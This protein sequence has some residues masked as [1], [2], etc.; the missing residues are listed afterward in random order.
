MV[1]HTL[2]LNFVTTVLKDSGEKIHSGW[3]FSFQKSKFLNFGCSNFPRLICV[4]NR[5]KNRD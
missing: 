2:Q 4:E 5:G 3:N 1:G